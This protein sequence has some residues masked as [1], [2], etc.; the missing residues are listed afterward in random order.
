MRNKVLLFITLTIFFS[1]MIFLWKTLFSDKINNFIQEENIKIEEELILENKSIEIIEENHKINLDSA[2]EIQFSYFPSTLNSSELWYKELYLKILKSEKFKDKISNVKIEFHKE[3][4]NVRWNMKNKTLRLFWVLKMPKNEL[5][6]VSIHE[7][8]H[9]IDLYFFD[10]Q[11]KNDIS[12]KFYTISWRNH[13]I[14]KKWLTVKDFVSGYAMSNKYE[15]FAESLTYFILHNND[16]LKRSEKSEILKRKYD[17]IKNSLF[18]NNSF[19]KQDFS[20][21]KI[22]LYYWDITKIKFSLEN[23]LLYLKK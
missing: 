5:I 2:Q 16:F 8:A 17:F 22:K 7:L 15:D 21:E 13:K 23:F 6:S 11:E 20:K 14:I 12:Y 10:V 18:K 3:K 9:Y 19:I 1:I 4:P